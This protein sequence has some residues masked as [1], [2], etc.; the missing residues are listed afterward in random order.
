MFW[1]LS[2]KSIN[3]YFEVEYEISCGLFLEEK[4]LL[5]LAST[6][7]CVRFIDISGGAENIKTIRIIKVVDKNIKSIMLSPDKTQIAVLAEKDRRIFFI[8]LNGESKKPIRIQGFVTLPQIIEQI[9]WATPFEEIDSNS[10][11][12]ITCNAILISVKA[13]K[14]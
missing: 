14:N 12:A 5:I 6:G 3:N 9:T 4:N 13:P 2:K 1:S 7:G 8:N 10:V 11:V